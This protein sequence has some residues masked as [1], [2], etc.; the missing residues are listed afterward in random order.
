[1]HM[2]GQTRTWGKALIPEEKAGFA[3]DGA[4]LGCAVVGWECPEADN[5]AHKGRRTSID[6][7]EGPVNSKN[8]GHCTRS[9]VRRQPYARA[10]PGAGRAIR[11]A[12]RNEAQREGGR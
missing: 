4:N 7:E 3:F 1:M 11:T 8:G 12:R 5:Q 6:C 2:V 9:V 10:D